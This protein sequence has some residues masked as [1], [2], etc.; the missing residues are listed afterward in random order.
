MERAN[1]RT[2]TNLEHHSHFHK[3]QNGLNL[4]YKAPFTSEK[5]EKNYIFVP[6]SIYSHK[7]QVLLT[8]KTKSVGITLKY[9]GDILDQ[10]HFQQLTSNKYKHVEYV[11]VFS[12]ASPEL[13]SLYENAK[14]TILYSKSE[15]FGLVAIES[16]ARGTPVVITNK[17]GLNTESLAPYLLSVEPGDTAQLVKAIDTLKDVK[18]DSEFIERIQKEYSW[19][20][21]AHQIETIYLNILQSND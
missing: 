7:N 14:L 18:I 17:T 16:L 20:K 12:S 5:I 9:A 21:I 2:L 8:D 15:T 1:Y 19:E 11:G 6:G 10:K 4:A 3:V 13:I